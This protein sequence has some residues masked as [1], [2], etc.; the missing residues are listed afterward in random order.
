LVLSLTGSCNFACKYCYAAHH[1]RQMMSLT[2]ALKA[3][4]LAVAAAEPFVLQFSGG[5]PLLAFDL[6]QAI[7]KFVHQQ[8]LP[9]LMQ[10]Q[11]NGSL[12]NPA[13]VAFLH[14]NAIGI[15]ISLDG[16]PEI[17]D[18]LRQLPDGTGTSPLTIKGCQTLAAQGVEV[19]IT[20]VV[21]ATNVTKL[22]GSVE[23]AYY[24]GNVRKIG[25]DLLRS[26]GQG[27]REAPPPADAI[28]A[29]LFAVF[30]TAQKWADLTGRTIH[31]AQ[32]ERVRQLAQAT[33]TGFSHCDA[34]NGE[35][36]FVDA[37]GQIYACSSLV[38]QEPFWLGD[39]EQGI[40]RK[41]QAQVVALLQNSMA[42]CRVCPDFPLCGGGC[43][44]RWRGWGRPGEAYEVE[45]AFKKAAIAW[46][47]NHLISAD[48]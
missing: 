37:A 14:D 13:I 47:Q 25:F 33:T 3:I 12:L 4:K 7:A 34:V 39:V 45:C 22:T 29:N 15:G 1:L 5:E 16:R 30:Q 9:A 40:I 48:K 10:I 27:F 43:F 24:L 20:T 8:H 42:V 35:A 19:G 28:R 36:A 31:F 21:T 6:I 41:R 2:T 17:N 32:L 46:Y 18:R 38:G 23:M 26:Q 44:A 11:T